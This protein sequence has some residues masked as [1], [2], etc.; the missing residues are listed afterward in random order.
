MEALKNRVMDLSLGA[1]KLQRIGLGMSQDGFSNKMNRFTRPITS[2]SR[3][4]VSGIVCNLY[5]KYSHAMVLSVKRDLCAVLPK[6]M[7]EITHFVLFQS[8]PKHF[9]GG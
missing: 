2:L 9:Y 5:A 8:Q 1:G 3:E 7:F 6:Q 4:S